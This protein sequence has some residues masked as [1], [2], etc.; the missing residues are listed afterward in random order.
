MFTNI[1]EAFIRAGEEKS[2]PP[3]H[4]LYREWAVIVEIEKHPDTA[5][6]LRA[7]E[8]AMGSSAAQ[9]RVNSAI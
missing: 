1:Q 2:I 7:A 4:M 8:Q 6:R 5:R 3:I 9:I